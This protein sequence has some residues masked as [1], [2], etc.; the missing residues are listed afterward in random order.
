MKRGEIYWAD[1]D[2]V[3]GSEQGGIR[4]VVVIQNN[5]GN[6]HSTTV[7][8]AAVTTKE[9]RPLP[10]HVPVTAAE[11]GLK[12]DSVVLTEQ[13]RTLEKTRLGR[14]LG[15]LNAQTMRR[16]D[17]ALSLSLGTRTV[18]EDQKDEGSQETEDQRKAL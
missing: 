9:K 14:R 10:I 16:V 18:S 15:S 5:M 2:P 1:L 13:V 12:Y 17:Q 11:S 7:I 3:I 4:P 8:V 6:R